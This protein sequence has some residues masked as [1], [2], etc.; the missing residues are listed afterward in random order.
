MVTTSNESL[1]MGAS[2]SAWK[3]PTVLDFDASSAEAHTEQWLDLVDR[4]PGA[5]RRTQTRP[6]APAESHEAIRAESTEPV[7]GVGVGAH[8]ATYVATHIAQRPS[9]A[10][11]NASVT[12][13][14]DSLSARVE[15]ESRAEPQPTGDT[16][17]SA[18]ERMRV[19]PGT[20]IESNAGAQALASS[21]AN[22]DHLAPE[23]SD[24]A[25]VPAEQGVMLAGDTSLADLQSL[26]LQQWP[27]NRSIEPYLSR[28]EAA[29]LALLITRLESTQAEEVR[30]KE[31]RRL[32]R[33]VGLVAVGSAV[34]MLVLALASRFD[35]PARVERVEPVPVVSQE[36]VVSP[37]GASVRFLPETVTDVPT[38]AEDAVLAPAPAPKSRAVVR[39]P[40]HRK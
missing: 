15:L 28:V 12:P 35:M 31:Q 30:R 20:S 4:T 3:M 5:G 40:A 25:P 18:S 27:A 8:V 9:D 2:D 7:P 17:A 29:Q 22:L 19:E 34:S 24:V 33:T 37:I 36:R 39:K 1:A 23:A 16:H 14:A 26:A 38:R 6:A 13:A 21:P 10:E 11:A 32:R